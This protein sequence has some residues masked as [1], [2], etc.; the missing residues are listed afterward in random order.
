M[1][2]R[3]ASIN[4]LTGVDIHSEDS[5]NGAAAILKAMTEEGTAVNLSTD[6]YKNYI[7]AYYTKLG[8][9]RQSQLVYAEA[10]ILFPHHTIEKIW[11]RE[12]VV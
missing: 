6:F 4:R 3:L 11:L 12:T 5:L 10:D 1:N 7:T 9:L 2:Q 8:E